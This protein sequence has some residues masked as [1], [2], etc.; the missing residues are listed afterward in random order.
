LLTTE[1]I[2]HIF[3]LKLIPITILSESHQMLVNRAFYV[4]RDFIPA[5]FHDHHELLEHEQPF[6]SSAK[7]NENSVK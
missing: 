5:I 4:F 1:D 6:A 7:P 3:Y 2:L